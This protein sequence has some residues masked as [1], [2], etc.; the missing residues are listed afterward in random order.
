MRCYCPREGSSLC[1]IMIVISLYN[2]FVKVMSQAPLPF[3]GRPLIKNTLCFKYSDRVISS[4]ASIM[5]RPSIQQTGA[6]FPWRECAPISVF[7]SHEL[8][9]YRRMV[10][11]LDV[12]LP[13]SR[14]LDCVCIQPVRSNSFRARLTVEQDSPKSE[15]MVFTPGQQEPEASDRSFR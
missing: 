10:Y 2:I 8:C 13:F 9:Y 7:P 12:L 3:P 15:A 14:Y 5:N 4:G 11:K 6:H 1:V